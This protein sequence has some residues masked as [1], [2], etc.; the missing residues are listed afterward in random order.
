MILSIIDKCADNRPSDY[1]TSTAGYCQWTC[2]VW[3][4]RRL[5]DLK[6]NDFP[7]TGSSENIKDTCKASCNNCGN[8]PVHL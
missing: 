6:W 7:C 8:S 4:E 2:Q 1:I 3:A 5:C